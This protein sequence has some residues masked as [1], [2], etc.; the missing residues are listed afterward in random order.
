MACSTHACDGTVV[1]TE[2]AAIRSC[3]S[4]VEKKKVLPRTMGPPSEKPPWLLRI[5]RVGVPGAAIGEFAA[6]ASW[7]LK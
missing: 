4:S 5:F 3:I 7:R 6:S 2:F 1:P